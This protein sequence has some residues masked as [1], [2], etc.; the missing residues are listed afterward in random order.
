MLY[1]HLWECHSEIRQPT[2]R[3]GGRGFIYRDVDT[4]RGVY[5]DPAE[6]TATHPRWL[7]C[8]TLQ[9]CGL[10]DADCTTERPYTTWFISATVYR[11][12]FA[13]LVTILRFSALLAQI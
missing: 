6:S 2:L 1:E 11:Q 8:A 7:R 9:G 5:V 12:P 4:A 3:K 13:A 10:H